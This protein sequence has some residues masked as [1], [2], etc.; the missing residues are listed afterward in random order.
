VTDIKGKLDNG[1]NK[2]NEI[3]DDLGNI[4]NAFITLLAD[5]ND[6]KE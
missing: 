6:I 2:G 5:I 1:S 4:I 3:E